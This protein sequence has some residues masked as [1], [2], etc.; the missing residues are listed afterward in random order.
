MAICTYTKHHFIKYKNLRKHFPVL[1]YHLQYLYI[2]ISLEIK[3]SYI[4]N[5]SKI[6]KTSLCKFLGRVSFLIPY[7]PRQPSFEHCIV[8]PRDIFLLAF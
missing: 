1:T 4:I 3:W 7:T 6:W 2:Y 5:S 8:Y